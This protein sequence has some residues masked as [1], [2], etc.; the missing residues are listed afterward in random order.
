MESSDKRNKGTTARRYGRIKKLRNTTRESRNQDLC[1]HALR[2][3]KTSKFIY[4]HVYVDKGFNLVQHY[5]KPNV[6]LTFKLVPLNKDASKYACVNT[7]K[8]GKPDYVKIN[9]I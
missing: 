6:Q 7:Q 9:R 5:K 1:G 3:T 4:C 2:M 8:W